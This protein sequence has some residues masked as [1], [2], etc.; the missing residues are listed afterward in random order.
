MLSPI[1]KIFIILILSLCLTGLIIFP[2]TDLSDQ[3][4]EIQEPKMHFSDPGNK[5]FFE[6]A[7]RFNKKD[8]DLS[9]KEIIAGIIPHH[10]LAADMISEFFYNLRDRKYDAVV[11]IGPDHYNK[12][13][14]KIS[15]SRYDWETPYGILKNDNSILDDL[16]AVENIRVDEKAMR[17]EHSMKS[18]TAFIKKYLPDSLIVP[19]ILRSDLES[20]EAGE[21]AEKLFEISVNKNIL[22]LG[23]VDFSHYQNNLTAQRHDRESIA[24][25][26]DRD[27]E[28]TYNLNVDS[29]PSIYTLLKFSELNGFNFQ[30]LNNSN[31][32]LLSGNLDLDSTT[33]YVTG[34]FVKEKDPIKMLFF[35]DLMVDRYVLER[36]ENNDPG[37]LLDNLDKKGFFK[38]Y[39]L[40]SANLEGAVTDKATHYSPEKMFDFAFNPKIIEGF[41]K[42]NFNFFNLA[43]NHFG[44]QGTR[45]MQESR[46]NLDKLGFDYSGCDNGMVDEC[47]AKVL[48]VDGMKIGMAGFSVL[49]KNIDDKIT[50]K[51]NDL[52]SKSDMVVVNIHWGDEYAENFSDRQKESAHKM[53]DAGADL[54]IGHHPH[55]V[56]GIEIYKNKAIFYSLGNFIF[57][58]YFDEETQKELAIEAII[59][60]NDI[61]FKIFP[62]ISKSSRVY[63]MEG[64][65]KEKMLEKISNNSNISDVSKKQIRK[66][67]LKTKEN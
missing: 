34:Y 23:S 58:Q 65:E 12:G 5:D 36:I 66:G 46:K 16:L 26:Q 8:I 27:M 61:E 1:V 32:A 55:V 52:K 47:S 43:N 53:I 35:G 44:D 42:Y 50:K 2:V 40:I 15:A 4:V 51:I 33:S 30:L 28:K 63:L 45:G 24:A 7:S 67:Y 60:G 17:D 20:Q 57:D 56:Q 39:D 22:L 13:R 14:S 62:L 29:P 9:D 18:E 41:K 48:N 21:L 59:R 37:S 64:G 38:D 54:I 49:G 10:L 19:L 31:S 11:L 25:L 6:T 3:N